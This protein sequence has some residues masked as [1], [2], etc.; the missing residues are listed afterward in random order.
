[1]V[2]W[3]IQVEIPLQLLQGEHP[4][5]CFLPPNGVLAKGVPT[6]IYQ[7]LLDG[8]VAN[9]LECSHVHTNAVGFETT[10]GQLRFQLI[11]IPRRN[12]TEG[13]IQLHDP[14]NSIQG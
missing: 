13:H 2:W 4:W 1:V 12:L 3:N 6:E 5:N 11:N 7:V 14:T 8:F 9:S 10:L